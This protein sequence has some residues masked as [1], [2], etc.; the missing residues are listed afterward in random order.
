MSVHNLLINREQAEYLVDALR[1][2]KGKL[3]PEPESGVDELIE[4]ICELFGMKN[5][6]Y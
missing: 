4:E 3:L 2:V 5:D 6:G 1:Y